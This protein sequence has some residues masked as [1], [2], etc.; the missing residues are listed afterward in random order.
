[1]L[2]KYVFALVAISFVMILMGCGNEGEGTAASQTETEE[3]LIADEGVAENSDGETDIKSEE[4]HSDVVD[5]ESLVSEDMDYY[6]VCTSKSKQEVEAFAEAVKV[7]FLND[8][9]AAVSETTAYPITIQGVEYVDAESLAHADIVLSEEYK[10]ALKAAS[11]ENL[12][13]N[14]EGIMLGDGEVW[15]GEVLDE[16]M[17]SEGLKIIAINAE[18]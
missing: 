3:S 1:M 14:G 16:D 6:S 11:C 7:S 9:W 17:Q 12:F 5:K 8:D 10:E 2:R 13:A 4:S 15:I 18:K